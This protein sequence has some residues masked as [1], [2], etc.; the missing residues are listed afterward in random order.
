MEHKHLNEVDTY[1]FN[2]HMHHVKND[3]NLK[4]KQI[5]EVSQY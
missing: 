4:I 3:I 5:K 1:V 2:N